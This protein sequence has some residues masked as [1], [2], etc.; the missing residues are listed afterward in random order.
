VIIME[1]TYVKNVKPGHVNVA[2][3]VEEIRK[4]GGLIFL[5]LR[6]TSGYIQ[7]TTPKKKVSDSVLKTATSLTKESVISVEGEAVTNK[8]APD[9]IEIIPSAIKIISAAKPLPIEFLGKA[10]TTFDK[11]LDYRS[12]SL[13]TPRNQAIFKIQS[14]ITHG[15][16][17]YLDKRDFLQI[18]TPCIL[19]AA[20]EGGADVFAVDYYKKHAFL[21]QDPQLHRQLAIAAGL[22]KIYELGPS[23]RAELSHTTRHL[24]EHRVLAMEMAFIKDEYDII[25]IQEEMILHC[26]KKIKTE[27][28]NELETFN[29][30][31]D[32]PKKIP[33]LKFPA[34]Y[35]IL[36]EMG[37]TVP[38]GAEYDTEGEELLWKWVKEKH[39]TDLFFV[40]RFPSAVKPFYVMKYDNEEWARS[41]DLL[42][43]GVELSSGGQREH[44]YDKIISQA[45]EKGIPIESIKWFADFFHYGVPPHGGFA[46]GIER[47]TKQLL[48]LGNI[49][50][51]TMFPRDVDRLLP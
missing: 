23:W 28:T 17:E 41:V 49:R 7:I 10:E 15:F 47:M 27:C 3:W 14:A 36:E 19:G 31:I 43:R 24:S 40:N 9:G 18:F 48:G 37:M 42:Y 50:E 26:L 45:K 33:V 30:K 25:K 35:D 34:V 22:E 4:L 6:D 44:R 38:H 20:S 32:I 11:L 51:A 1:R 13:R 39:K 46:I 5:K 2:G 8:E 29:T 16:I 21:R 12:L